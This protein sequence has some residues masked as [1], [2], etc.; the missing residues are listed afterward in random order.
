MITVLNDIRQWVSTGGIWVDFPAVSISAWHKATL[1]KHGRKEVSSF[2]SDITRRAAHILDAL[3]RV[4]DPGSI[5]DVS[6]CRALGRKLT[7]LNQLMTGWC[8]A[9][10]GTTKWV[11]AGCVRIDV[12]AKSIPLWDQAAAIEIS[13]REVKTRASAVKRIG[14]I[15][16]RTG[17][18]C[19][20]CPDIRVNFGGFG[21]CHS[22]SCWDRSLNGFLWLVLEEVT[23]VGLGLLAKLVHVG[24]A[25]TRANSRRQIRLT[26]GRESTSSGKFWHG[27]VCRWDDSASTRST[28]TGTLAPIQAR[29]SKWAKRL[30][31][32]RKNGTKIISTNQPAAVSIPAARE[33]TRSIDRT[34]HRLMGHFSRI[35]RGIPVINLE[36][37]AVWVLLDSVRLPIQHILRD[38][39]QLRSAITVIEPVDRLAVVKLTDMLNVVF[40]AFVREDRTRLRRGR[41]RTRKST[42]SHCDI[43][44]ELSLLVRIPT[45]LKELLIFGSVRC[46][47]CLLFG[48]TGSQFCLSTL[49]SRTL[50]T[51][52]KSRNLLTGLHL[53][54]KISRNHTLLTSRRLNSL[55]VSLLIQRCDS[56]SGPQLLLTAEIRTFQTRTVATESTGT[57]S[58]RLLG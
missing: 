25:F 42:S 38:Q 34:A 54:S 50:S 36:V 35:I 57:N 46:L 2:P 56:L 21:L 10:D 29:L 33:L 11:A 14:F 24:N 47:V 19:T 48:S 51:R 4:N 58:L 28:G 17:L 41:G 44:K 52:A 3:G 32:R 13:F 49:E 45:L 53:T 43:G 23:D 6:H 37:S 1:S 9:L 30:L 18:L 15:Q 40:E 5:L 20:L 7:R 8:S 26:L 39:T 27:K 55:I 31:L 16:V 12:S 22:G